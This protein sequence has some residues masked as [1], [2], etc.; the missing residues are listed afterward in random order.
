[1]R[2][3]S[4]GADTYADFV[5]IVQDELL[6]TSFDQLLR[7]YSSELKTMMAWPGASAHFRDMK[8][9]PGG[10]VEM[11]FVSVLHYWQIFGGRCLSRSQQKIAQALSCYQRHLAIVKEYVR[12]IA[13]TDTDNRAF[14]AENSLPVIP[15]FLSND[16]SDDLM[17]EHHDMA[18]MFL[19]L[20]QEPRHYRKKASRC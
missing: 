13:G 17:L 20:V 19:G 15:W 1:M 10:Q 5:A 7:L 9:G 2:L 12:S 18:M 3:L 8:R 14:L 16:V 11:E 6:S 4:G